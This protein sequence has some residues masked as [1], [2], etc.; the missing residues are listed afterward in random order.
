MKWHDDTSYSMEEPCTPY[1]K[2]KKPYTKGNSL[3][4]GIH[5]ECLD[6]A[7]QDRKWVSG[8]QMMGAEEQWLLMGTGFLLGDENVLELDESNG[9]TAVYNQWIIHLKMEKFMLCELYLYLKNEFHNMRCE[10]RIKITLK[11]N[12]LLFL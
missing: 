7:N 1:A 5:M 4:D 3:Y 2:W 12:P 9:C 11:V 6:E 8:C 10:K